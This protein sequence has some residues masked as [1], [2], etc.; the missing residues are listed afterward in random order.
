M[1]I[2]YCQFILI[3]KLK[4]TLDDRNGRKS[5][6]NNNALLRQSISHVLFGILFGVF[7]YVIKSPFTFFYFT[8]TWIMVM[9][10]MMIISEFTTILFDTSENAIIQPL[11]VPGN[12]ISLARNAHIFIYLA[13][14]ALNLSLV[15]I[16]IGII[17]FGIL[18]GL[19]LIF[20]IFLNVLLTLFI[21]NILYLGIMRLATGEKLKNLLMYFQIFI[22]IIFMAAYQFGLK[23]IDTSKITDMQVPVSW[24]SFLMPPAFFS[25]FV[26]AFSFGR[27]DLIHFEFIAEALV[28]PLTAI[29]LTGKFLTPVFNRKL[30]ELELGDR[31]NKKDLSGSRIGIYYRI[32]SR[33][34]VFKSEEKVAFTLMW[35]LAGRERQFKQ[36]VFPAF[37]YIII[38][39]LVPFFSKHESLASV[40]NSD[41]YLIILYAFLILAATI[42][43]STMHG[44]GSHAS[45][46]FK[47]L[48]VNSPA[49]IFRG[50]I[51]AA[52]ALFFIPLYSFIC[53][54]AG[55]LWG[56]RIVPDIIVASLAIYLFTLL[57]YYFQEPVFPFTKEK[58]AANSGGNTIRMF[59]IFIFAIILGF[60]HKLLLTMVSNGSLILIPVYIGIIIYVNRIF[61]YRKITWKAVNN[62]NEYL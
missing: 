5:K 28:I 50:F 19:I 1:G 13:L 57:Y 48:P 40:L 43:V 22:A 15:T 31:S 58:V 42:P 12:T 10:A 41:R 18:A 16:V 8:H 3:L 62:I 30:M 39:I 61:V 54:A 14:I 55:V 23:M 25:G 44:A 20:S 45:W 26:E 4:L 6:K 37:G 36:A 29:Y 2:D 11:P 27:F 46:I 35:K 24:H 21:S 56:I 34:F 33:L 32:M 49:E 47:V 59:V 51:K 17:K 9:M 52:F 38:M 60:L 7:V 53:I